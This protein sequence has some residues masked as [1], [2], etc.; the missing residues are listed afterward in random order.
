MLSQVSG[1]TFHRVRGACRHCTFPWRQHQ[2]PH[3][4]RPVQAALVLPQDSSMQLI[5]THLRHKQ[6][7][8]ATPACP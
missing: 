5:W 3:S 8:G 2:S 7:R 6:V 1:T 4:S